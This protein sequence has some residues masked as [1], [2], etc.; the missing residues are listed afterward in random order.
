[1]KTYDEL[2]VNE[3]EKLSTFLTKRNLVL[4]DYNSMLI[5]AEVFFVMT[6]ILGGVI[7]LAGVSLITPAV[8]FLNAYQSDMFLALA[9]SFIQVS[10]VIMMIGALGYAIM[11]VVAF[12]KIQKEKKK[13]YLIFG[14]HSF[15]KVFDIKKADIKKLNKTWKKVK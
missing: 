14:Y 8:L 9:Y 5:M 13:D 12:Y 15:D 6:F 10:P 4:S 1:M 7:I 3:K 2:S 11:A